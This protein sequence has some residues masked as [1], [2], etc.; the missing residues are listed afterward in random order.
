MISLIVRHPRVV[1]ILE[2]DCS[3]EDGPV[4]R[5]HFIQAV[6]LEGDM[7][8]RGF[9]DR[10]CWP[11]KTF[12]IAHRNRNRGSPAHC[13]FC[14]ST[15]C[16][17]GKFRGWNVRF[18]SGADIARLLSNVRFTPQS[19]QSADMLACPLCAISD[20][21]HCGKEHRYS[22]TS[23]ARTSSVGGMSRPSDPPPLKWSDL[24]YVF[25]IQEDCN[26]KEA[27]QA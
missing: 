2:V 25:D 17:Q 14:R 9:D 10:H 18:G 26:G 15:R 19:G 13:W 16:A 3:A 23:S 4:P 20:R 22:I 11:P 1:V 7:M 12:S 8:Q 24:R 6:R 27:I 5:D 21:L